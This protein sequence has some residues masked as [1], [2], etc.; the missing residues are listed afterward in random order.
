MIRARTQETHSPKSKGCRRT[1][2][3]NGLVPH[4]VAVR[5][6]PFVSKR[7]AEM[8]RGVF[9]R[10]L[11]RLRFTDDAEPAVPQHNVFEMLLHRPRLVFLLV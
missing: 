9:R 8:I 7:A 3:A 2:E 11:S 10:R 5:V 4:I 1:I 6:A